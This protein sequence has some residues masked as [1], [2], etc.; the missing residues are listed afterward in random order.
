[1]R[2]RRK[3]RATVRS[4]YDAS[5]SVTSDRDRHRARTLP[6]PVDSASLAKRSHTRPESR[7]RR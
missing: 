5:M 7:K 2:P 6:P 4:W 3:P 1:M